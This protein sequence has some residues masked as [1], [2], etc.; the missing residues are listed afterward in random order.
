MAG[1][2]PSLIRASVRLGAIPSPAEATLV[3]AGCRSYGDQMEIH[4]FTRPRA[5]SVWVARGRPMSTRVRGHAAGLPQVRGD[6]G[7]VQEQLAG[8]AGFRIGDRQ[9]VGVQVDLVPGLG[10]GPRTGACR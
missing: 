2:P 1:L 10:G 6:G 5:S 3:S 9:H 7:Q 4:F 8:L